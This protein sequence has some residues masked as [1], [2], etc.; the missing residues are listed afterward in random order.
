MYIIEKEITKGNSEVN[1]NSSIVE[2]LK[3]YEDLCRKHNI[4]ITHEDGHGAFIFEKF[5]ENNIK[6]MCE[7][8]E[9]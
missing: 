6:Y 2:F 5:N 3:E 1:K 9:W 8:R 7:G 4:S